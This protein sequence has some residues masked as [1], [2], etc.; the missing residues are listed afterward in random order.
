MSNW[1]E[2]SIESRIRKILL[3]V[4]PRESG[5]H[6]G[7]QF[8]TAYQIAICFAKRYP[9]DYAAIGKEIGGK[10]TGQ[11]DSLAQYFANQLSRRIKSGAL[12][13]IEGRFLNLRHLRALE[14][15]FHGRCVESSPG[16]SSELSIFRFADD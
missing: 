3:E 10:A 7:R 12:T 4:Q 14:F 16:P 1:E 11:K 15:D 2:F 5:H 13:G 8:L 6:F 9:G